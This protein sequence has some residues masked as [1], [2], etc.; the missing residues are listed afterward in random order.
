MQHSQRLDQRLHM[1]RK[2]VR[3]MTQ[4]KEHGE[5]VWRERL[6]R[7]Q[8]QLKAKEDEMSRQCQYFENFKTQ[9]QQK[10]SLAR[11][12]EQSLQNRIYS[13]EK[14]LLNMTVSAATGTTAISAVRITAGTVT[15]W[16]EPDKLPPMRGEG[17]GEEERKEEERKQWQAGERRTEKN[18]DKNSNEARLQ[19]FILS[20]QEDLKV[21]LE[22]EEDWVSQRRGLLEQLQEAQENSQFMCCKVEEMKAEVHLLKQSESSMLEEVEELRGENHRL[23]QIIGD[24]AN[25]TSCQPPEVSESTCVD[26]GTGSPTFS[27][28]VHPEPS[29]TVLSTKVLGYTSEWSFEEAAAESSETTTENHPPTAKSE[30][31]RQEDPL[32]RSFKSLSCTTE[33]LDELKLGTW[34]SRGILNLEES[35]SEESDA[36]RDAYRSLGFGEDLEALK[37]QR[38]RLEVAL[39]HAQEQ[40]EVMTQETTQLKLELMKKEDVQ[41][42]EESP[43]GK[44]S[45]LLTCDTAENHI[46]AQDDLVQ[47]LNQENRALAD[48]IQELLSHIELREEEIKREET[49]LRDFISKLEADSVRLGQQNQD[50]MGLITELTKKTEDDL[51]TIMELQQRFEESELRTEG[52]QADEAVSGSQLQHGNAA[53]LSRSFQL[54][55]LEESTEGLVKNGLKKEES[56]LMPSQQP[57]ASTSA[58]VPNSQQNNHSDPVLKSQE[59][60]SIQSLKTEQRELLSDIIS[61]KEQQREVTLSVKTQTEVKQQLTRTVWGL[62]E[63]KDSI[64]QSLAGVKQA[65]EQLTRAVCGLRDEKDQ[66]LKS[67]SDMKEEKEQLTGCLLVLRTE[68]Q[69]LF[70][71]VSCGKEERAQILQSIESLQTE[72]ERLNQAVLGLK[73]ERDELTASVESLKGQKDK[74]QSLY[75]LQEDQDMLRKSVSGL[76][77]EKERIEQSVSYLKEE[78]K[79]IKLCLQDLREEKNSHQQLLINPNS[80]AATK[81]QHTETLFEEEATQQHQTD[82]HRGNPEEMQRLHSELRQS[83]TRREEAERKVA[84]AANELMRLTDVANQMGETSV[85][86]DKLKTQVKELQSKLRGVIKEKTDALSLKAQI[87]EQ[88]NILTAQLKAKTVALEELTLEYIT[89]K[90]RKNSNDMST[91]MISLRTRYNDIR[92]KYDDLVKTRSQMDLEITPLKA[93]LSCLVVKCQERNNLLVQMMKT[94]NRHGSVDIS[95]TQQVE[96]VL[97]DAALQDYTAA[98]TPGYKTKDYS[99]GLTPGFI[100]KLQDYTSGF[101]PDQSC[102]L[103]SPPV[104]QQNGFSSHFGGVCR[105]LK[106]VEL[107]SVTVKSSRNEDCKSEVPSIGTVKRDASS[108]VKESTRVSETS[109]PVV[110]K[111][112]METDTAQLSP[113]VCGLTQANRAPEKLGSNQPAIKGKSSSDS[114]RST[115][116][117]PSPT[118]LTSSTRVSANRRLSSPEKILNLH[119]QLQKT[120]QSSYQTPV[121]RGRRQQ[122]RKCLLFSDSATD[123]EPA[124]VTKKQSFSFHKP[125]TNSLPVNTALSQAK[126]TPAVMAKTPLYTAVTSRSA[127]ITFGPDMFT[128]NHSKAAVSKVTM[129]PLNPLFAAKRDSKAKSTPSSCTSLTKSPELTKK[130]VVICDFSDAIHETPALRTTSSDSKVLTCSDTDPKITASGTT[131]PGTSAASEADCYDT[132]PKTV[133]AAP[134]NERLAF[135]ASC[136]QSAH[137]PSKRPIIPAAPEVTKK[138]RPKPEAPAEVRSVEVIKTV[139]QSCLMIGWE[140]PALDELGCSNGTFVYGY[141]VFVGGDFHKSVMSSAC[142]K[143]ILENVDL[144]LPV[145]ISVQTLGANGLTS[146]SIHTLYRMSVRRDHSPD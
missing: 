134:A 1:L 76:R 4:E 96:E 146:D 28:A 57:D 45:T 125:H 128:N 24:T 75:T 39:Q 98:F 78:E 30:T 50:Q 63:E 130:N 97:N 126:F 71:S 52:E 38:D 46:I 69:T 99:T 81:R 65:R 48:R 27:A 64:S 59:V 23:Q 80:P 95:L 22:R 88:Y 85:E 111:E 131:A 35:P 29:N 44:M 115:G 122:P 12:R 136:T 9:L 145:H 132:P 26:P 68:K 53:E 6:Q 120:L 116:S 62:K 108:P 142:T 139:G 18:K 21:L 82:A 10:L 16:E 110:L 86:N 133:G 55:N 40:L 67:M 73:Q 83:E 13:L 104:N 102:S 66:L 61:L 60:K 92:A 94:M 143:C 129:P 41:E 79:Q 47:A 118:S 42:A 89:L 8:R 101:T 138:V 11:D 15:R 112:S 58:L 123:I 135:A 103:L 37:E 32:S 90:Q 144:S 33:I 105:D 84:Q 51:N 20:L 7:C 2:D 70:E 17:E 117:S 127:N 77:E 107:S 113:S 106:S 119:E 109:S 54:S 14:Q 19:G 5:Q 72:N 56:Y 34:C 31:P 124:P 114:A 140:R 141:R 91:S 74:E 137:P 49:R 36:L 3:T 25:L 87:E 100:S 93:K 121:S 43:N